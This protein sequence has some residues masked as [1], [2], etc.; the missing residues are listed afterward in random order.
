MFWRVFD[1][2]VVIWSAKVLIT[3]DG[4]QYNYFQRHVTLSTY[5]P[6]QGNEEVT[7]NVPCWANKQ[8]Q[9]II[10]IFIFIFN[11]KEKEVKTKNKI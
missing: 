9:H 4:E 6:F 10:F 2:D 5:I 7:K 11:L 8:G 1:V 3:W